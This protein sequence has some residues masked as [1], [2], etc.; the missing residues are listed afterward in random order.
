MKR[1]LTAKS[2]ENSGS[3]LAAVAVKGLIKEASARDRWQPS[4]KGNKGF[5]C[6]IEN[7]R[8]NT[9]SFFFH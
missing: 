7:V 5:W 8:K 1:S 4:R 3:E 9:L 6:K 2:S